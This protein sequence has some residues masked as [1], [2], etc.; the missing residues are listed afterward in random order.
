MAPKQQ[1]E[2]ADEEQLVGDRIEPLIGSG[3]C[4]VRGHAAANEQD[5]R[6][7]GALIRKRPC[8]VTADVDD[9]YDQQRHAKQRRTRLQDIFST[10]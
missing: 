4:K 1:G 10:S 8:C 6:G 9:R 7:E 2:Q 3:A 5:C